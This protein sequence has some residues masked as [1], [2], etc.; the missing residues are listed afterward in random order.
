MSNIQMV[1]CACCE[2]HYEEDDLQ[3]IDGKDI[4]SDCDNEWVRECDCCGFKSI[5]DECFIVGEFEI[6]CCDCSK[7]D[8]TSMSLYMCSH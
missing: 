1:K 4:C 6:Y 7:P 3:D 5:D 8:C 2:Q